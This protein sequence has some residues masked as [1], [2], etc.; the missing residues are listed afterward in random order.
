METDN[1][2]SNLSIVSQPNPKLQ[3]PTASYKTR[4]N[5]RELVFFTFYFG[6]MPLITLYLQAFFLATVGGFTYVIGKILGPKF[7]LLLY[8]SYD[9]A[10]RV[11]YFLFLYSETKKRKI[12][13]TK[14]GILYVLIF[15]AI[16]SLFFNLLVHGFC[17]IFSM[18]FMD[19]RLSDM[20][21]DW[22]TVIRFYNYYILGILAFMASTLSRYFLNTQRRSM[23]KAVIGLFLL[24]SCVPIFIDF[25]VEIRRQKMRERE[26]LQRNK[27][28][29]EL[30]L[31]YV[32]LDR[33][34][35]ELMSIPIRFD[36]G[37]SLGEYLGD[38]KCVVSDL[39]KEKF[40]ALW[41]CQNS[42]N[43][44]VLLGKYNE[45][46]I[47]KIKDSLLVSY[48]ALSTDQLIRKKYI[49]SISFSG[50]N[51]EDNHIFVDAITGETICRLRENVREAR[52]DKIE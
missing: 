38:N 14:Q 46:N 41:F 22:K 50:Q 6:L 45:G 47:N 19:C 10:F 2:K 13:N 40:S 26:E 4:I 25:N 20:Y 29:E 5:Y 15:T 51:A 33:Q 49:W 37:T 12:E 35:D 39:G 52:Y 42:R 11:A 16:S 24:I 17:T 31:E 43:Y 9:I 27:S 44:T 32:D 28:E 18:G 48:C 7:G 30:A 23:E 21:S 3:P 1:Q 34:S 8:F 36:V